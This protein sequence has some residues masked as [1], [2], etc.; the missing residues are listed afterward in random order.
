MTLWTGRRPQMNKTYD[1]KTL[2]ITEAEQLK[3]RRIRETV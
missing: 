1:A 3:D 2:V